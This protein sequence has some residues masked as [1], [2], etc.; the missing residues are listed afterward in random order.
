M[1]RSALHF[2][3]HGDTYAVIQKLAIEQ[4]AAFLELTDLTSIDSHADIEI[5]VE[6]VADSDQKYQAAIYVRI[7]K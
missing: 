1:T 7:K 3:V 4:T 2:T 6:D 5:S